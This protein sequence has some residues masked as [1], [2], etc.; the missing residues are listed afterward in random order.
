[1]KLKPFVFYLNNIAELHLLL[2]DYWSSNPISMLKLSKG[3]KMP[4]ATLNKFLREPTANF[5][6]TTYLKIYKFL[7][8]QSD[9]K[10]SENSEKAPD[11]TIL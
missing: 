5:Y 10:G 11:N 3:L 2:W 6:C 4:P 9:E 7:V 1:M 8:S